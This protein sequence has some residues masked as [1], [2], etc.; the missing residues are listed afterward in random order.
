MQTAWILVG[1]G[2]LLFLLSLL[3]NTLGIAPNP[4]FGWKKTLGV[5]VGIVLIVVGLVMSR[6]SDMRR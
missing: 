4:G 2:V 1:V 3:A 6:R 5:V